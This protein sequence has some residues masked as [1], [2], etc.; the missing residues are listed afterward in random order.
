MDR[1]KKHILLV[2]LFGYFTI[3]SVTAQNITPKT[4]AS[5]IFGSSF[6]N[7]PSL[8]FGPG[9]RTT[10]P[11]NYTLGPGDELLINISGSQELNIRP[12]VQ[13]GGTVLIPRVGT[14]NVAGLPVYAAAT[15]IKTKLIQ[16]A[17]PSLSSGASKLIVS[18]GKQRDIHITIIGAS[19]PGIYPVS[20]LATVFNV[21]N[22]CGGPG[23]IYTY[24]NVEL[25]RNTKRYA[26]ID[27]YKFLTSGDLSGNIPLKDSDIINFPVYKKRVSISGQVKTNGIFE[28]NDG[29]NFEKLLFFAGGYTSNAYKASV[30]VKQLS[31]N[32]SRIKDIPASELSAY[33]PTEGDEFT[34]DAIADHENSV[35]I[36]GAV[37][38]SGKFE[39]TP[40]LTIA[41]VLKRAGGLQNDAFTNRAILT[42]TYPDGR[43]Q[44]VVFDLAKIMNDEHADIPLIKRDVIKIAAIND[45]TDYKV[46]ITGEVNNPGEFAYTEGLSLKNILN[47]AGGFTGVAPLYYIEVSRHIISNQSIIDSVA[48]AFTVSTDKDIDIEKNKFILQ[49]FDIVT[50]RNPGYEAPQSVSISGEVVNPGIYT[51]QSKKEHISDLIKL[52][53]GLTSFA[54]SDSLY[55]VRQAGSDN[56]Q[57]SAAVKNTSANSGILINLKKITVNPASVE[58]YVLSG[59]DVVQILK[60]GSLA[61]GNDVALSKKIKSKGTKKSRIIGLATGLL[62]VAAL[63]FVGITVLGK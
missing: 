16:T 54:N 28:L 17:Y 21:L 34:V 9:L 26:V 25:I 15:R 49:P 44:N 8:S 50:V 18:P 59:G 6:F 53:G 55:L 57:Q 22:L 2:I 3:Y 63:L 19:K 56:A 60:M 5:T 58:N 40:G 4:S 38:K 30:R 31:D 48:T 14:V 32:G 29:E 51:I 42:R 62:S 41:A 7:S 13:P 61:K 10:P 24:R 52:A 27:L 20:P 47:L 11:A 43:I 33:L 23:D 46:Q 35:S 1:H 37:N 36:G 39:I 45:N 12:I